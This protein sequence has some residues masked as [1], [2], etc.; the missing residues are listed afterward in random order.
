MTMLLHRGKSRICRD[1]LPTPRWRLSII[2]KN[3]K[4]Q[5]FD[6]F[7]RGPVSQGFYFSIFTGRALDRLARA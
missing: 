4:K 3:M 7:P 2:L 6:D 1:S 5:A